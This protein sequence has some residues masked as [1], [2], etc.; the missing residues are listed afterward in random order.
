MQAGNAITAGIA[1]LPIPL[2]RQGSQDKTLSHLRRN[3]R[4][5]KNTVFKRQLCVEWK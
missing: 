5:F 4:E 3:S 1:K 2:R